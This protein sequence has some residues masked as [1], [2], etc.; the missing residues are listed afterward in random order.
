MARF[1]TDELFFLLTKV[2]AVLVILSL[3]KR[4]E[5]QTGYVA[6]TY[7]N[8]S[9]SYQNRQSYLTDLKLASMYM[10]SLIISDN[11]LIT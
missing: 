5:T 1:L 6:L 7:I 8:F 10:F 9:S 11:Q 2:A 3:V 4:G